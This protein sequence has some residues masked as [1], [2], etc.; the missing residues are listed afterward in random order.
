[1]RSPVLLLGLLACSAPEAIEGNTIA[2]S[3]DGAYLDAPFPSDHRLEQGRVQILDFPNP[4]RIE[5][6]TRMR[7]ILTREARGFGT[8]SGIFF[9]LSS[10]LLRSDEPLLSYA[11]SLQSDAPVLLLAVSPGP[12]YLQPHPIEARFREDGGPHGAENLLSLLPLQGA[13][14]QPATRYAAVVLR[15]LSDPP[16]GVSLTV[17]QLL[18]GQRPQA[19]SEEAY[20][21]Y[22]QAIEALQELDLDL[23]EVAGL[24]VFTTDDPVAQLTRFQTAIMSLPAPQL[25]EPWQQIEQHPNYCVFESAVMMPVYQAGTPPFE[26]EG[27][28]F[29]YDESSAPQV[30]TEERSRVFVT[31][32]RTAAPADGFPAAVF[33]RT[34]GGG[35]RPLIDR[36]VRAEPG[37]PA[38]DAGTGPARELAQAGFAG[39]S[40]DGPHGGLRN[41]T[42]GDEQF[43]IFNFFNPIAMRD[44]IR[45]SALELMLLAH[46]LP[47]WRLPTD[48]C[49]ELGP[50]EAKLSDSQTVLMGHSMG[51][52]IAPLALALEPRYRALILSGAGGS[53]IHNIVHKRSPLVVKPLAELVLDYDDQKA[54]LHE[55]DPVLS[56]LQWAGEPA[57]PP[58]YARMRADRHILMLQGVVDTYILPPIANATS[59][60]YGLE[61][62]GEALEPSLPAMLSLLGRATREY[63]VGP[64]QGVT[65]VV[66]QHAEG[67]IEDGHEVVFQTEAPKRQYRCFLKTFLEG[68]PTVPDGTQDGCP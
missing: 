1:M 63:P 25:L 17:R 23:E 22:Q 43:L 28:G 9:K 33:I 35:D 40:I 11:Q 67:P 41:I 5:F 3:F 42:G 50:E 44:N 26:S 38:I 15:S 56:L 24:T 19:L 30:Q 6:V 53:W 54:S 49:A 31:L 14:L 16:L 51:A 64:A 66:V 46:L 48:G 12:A 8:T 45:Q 21:S 2:T 39:V 27:G 34:G 32:P 10:P 57:D 18:E 36:G 13:P 65:A 68:A 58:V 47:S 37:G 20:D 61:L 52:T 4:Q 62:A 55:H 60:S 29:G 59:L 7:Q